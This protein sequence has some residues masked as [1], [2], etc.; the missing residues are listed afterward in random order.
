MTTNP[1]IYVPDITTIEY[2][3]LCIEKLGTSGN[4]V[5]IASPILQH[6]GNHTQDPDPQTQ[7][8]ARV[9]IQAI[10]GYCRLGSLLKTGVPIRS[11]GRLRC[12]VRPAKGKNRLPLGFNANHLDNQVLQVCMFLTDQ[13]RSNGQRPVILVSKDANL[14]HR[15]EVCGIRAEDYQAGKIDDVN[16][17]IY[18]C[19]EHVHLHASG[20]SPLQLLYKD[21]K[22]ALDTLGNSVPSE[23]IE[24]LYEN[25]CVFLHTHDGKVGQAIY[26]KSL[27]VF[28]AVTPVHKRPP[29]SG[30][31]PITDMQAFGL[32][33]LEDSSIL[34][35][36][37]VG[38]A[39]GGKTLL[40]MHWAL[41]NQDKYD[42]IMV[43][44]SNTEA[45]NPMGFLPGDLNE[46]F[47][48][49]RDPIEITL[50]FL[51]K[52]RTRCKGDGSNYRAGSMMTEMEGQGKLVVTPPNF[53]RG[54]TYHKT[55]IIVDDAQNWE[56][57][58]LKLVLTRA[59]ENSRVII[60]G[61]PTQVDNPRLDISDNGLVKAISKFR[62]HPIFG[63][64]YLPTSERS[65]IA[66]LSTKL[67]SQIDTEFWHE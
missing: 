53:V 43:F 32:A 10:D 22:I 11:G 55:L 61:D 57:S 30:F 60:T 15:A 23:A 44:R 26:K 66:A 34:I 36:T 51:S 63:S 27:G 29:K 4:D 49:Y 19:V 67:G 54:S 31:A 62:G 7:Y 24:R 38:I 41:E 12:E 18:N 42:K 40:A 9:A 8:L 56:E 28:R 65:E 47:S 2:E 3:P 5:V 52:D 21:G 13:E 48:P 50:E 35:V 58:L 17:T 1:K 46:K 14:R 37:L 64:I 6:L 16:T 33:L 20:I 45:G 39:G 59:G 25:Q